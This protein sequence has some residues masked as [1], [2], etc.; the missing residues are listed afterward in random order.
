MKNGKVVSFVAPKS[1]K[2]LNQEQTVRAIIAALESRRASLPTTDDTVLTLDVVTEKPPVSNTSAAELGIVELIGSASTR[3]TGSPKNR[4]SNIKNGVKFL[5]GILIPPGTEFSTIQALGTIDNTTG[6]LPELV[7]KEN[8]TIPEYGGGLCQ[9]STTLFRATMNAGLPITARRNHS[10]RVS[11]YEVDGD[12]NHIGPGL[13]ATIYNPNPD[14]KFVNDTG[15]HILIQGHVEGD[16]ITFDF[17][18]TKDG[19]RSEIDGPRTLST[20]GAGEPIYVETDTLPPGEK[21][22]IEKAHAGGTAIATYRIIY[23]DGTVKE[24]EYRSHYKN[25]PAQYLVGVDPSKP[26][27]TP[28]TEPAPSETPAPTP[29]PSP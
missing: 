2:R 18:G 17:Y 23:A 14:F 27:E 28:G 1:G 16:K 22:Q 7:I 6:Y 11:Y 9:V 26:P 4:V 8:R 3:F 12:G 29:T 20:W 21:K 13:D 10:Y 25:W 15:A 19:R 24:E 5:S